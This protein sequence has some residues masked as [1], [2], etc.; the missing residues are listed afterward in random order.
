[1]PKA[2]EGEDALKYKGLSNECCADNLWRRKSGGD[3]GMRCN[4]EIV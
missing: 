3:K 2:E 1:M 4:Q